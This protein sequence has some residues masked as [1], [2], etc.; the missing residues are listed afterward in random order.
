MEGSGY[1][2][3]Q[4]GLPSLQTRSRQRGSGFLG[5]LKRFALPLAKSLLPV[6]GRAAL[7]VLGGRSAKETLKERG[8]E[9]GKHAVGAIAREVIPEDEQQPPLKRYKRASAPPKS[10]I[11]MKKKKGAKRRR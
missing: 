1:P 4:G 2:I 11:K 10:R 8:L 5:A 9:A 3:F 7:D 6:A